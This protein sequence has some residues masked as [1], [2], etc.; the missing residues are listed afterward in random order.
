MEV[1][2]E[3]E[4][5]ETEV[6]IGE[7][8][9]WRGYTEEEWGYCEE[10]PDLEDSPEPSEDEERDEPVNAECP[11]GYSAGYVNSLVLGADTN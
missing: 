11:Y 7:F 6:V 10:P 1:I 5:G 4:D 8:L 9:Y 3:E 2:F